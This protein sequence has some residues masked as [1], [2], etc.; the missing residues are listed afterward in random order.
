MRNLREIFGAKSSRKEGA[1]A[2]RVDQR[3]TNEKKLS[4]AS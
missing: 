4:V 1:L 3:R 2:H